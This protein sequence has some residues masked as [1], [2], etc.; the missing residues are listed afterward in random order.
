MSLRFRINLIITVLIVLFSLVTAK[1]VVDDARRSIR[2]EMEA[3]TKV[4]L[5]LLT[6]MLYSSRFVPPTEDPNYV[7]RAFLHSLGRVRA[8]E[9]RLYKDDG[10][11]VYT[12]PPPV[13]K[14]GRA[15]PHWFSA[16]VTPELPEVEL[17]VRSGR[18]IVTPDASRSIL[19]AWDDM[20]GLIWLALG[21]LVLVNVVVFWLLGRALR[22][23]K[24]ILLGLSE[25]ERGRLD[26]RLPGFPLPEFDSISHTFN[27]MADALEESHAENTRLALVA[28]Q[29]SDAIMIHDL[30]GNISFWNPA[31]ERLFGYKPDQIVGQSATLLTPPGLEA[32]V[33]ENLQTICS[34]RVVDNVETRRL[35]H[36]GRLVDVALSAAPLVDPASGQ[37]IG[38]ICSMRDITE[39]KHAKETER[40][41]E[42]N[43]RLTQLIQTRLEEERRSIARELHDELGQCVTAIKTIGVAI[44]NRTAEAA[45]EIHRSAQTIVQVAG[46][47]YDVVH[48]I[49]R[50]LRPS[51]LDH[52]GLREAIEDVVKSWGNRHPEI[53][54]EL[55]LARDLGDLGEAV[56]IT[57][58]RLIQECLTNL[59]RHSAASRARIEV[60]RTG[61]MVRVSVSDDGKG[62]G[63]RK[64]SESARFGLMGMRE[65]VQ[66]LNG[67]FHLESRP[68]EGLKVSAVIPVPPP[69]LDASAAP[70]D[71]TVGD[72][73]VTAR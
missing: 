2:E 61:G 22:P 50:Q 23:V 24:P 62:L 69:A 58:Y 36:D 53:T 40:E 26:T 32:E 25:M 37:V 34:R 7:L 14:A 46:H 56:N 3:G 66:A 35:T 68:G 18:I 71:N 55:Q 70:E 39:R 63:E 17:R 65:R 28:K 44:A 20:K 21:F 6:T 33:A 51:A 8:N 59:I 67:E 54:C 73:K 5:Q 30:T 29:S 16:L 64:E 4:T 27:R 41:L 60:N 57:I 13:Y 12:S 72:G 19:D 49:I 42:Q 38:E 47:I 15:A 10:T 11:L 31:A 43:R 9:I 48:G 52:L 45:P 1:I